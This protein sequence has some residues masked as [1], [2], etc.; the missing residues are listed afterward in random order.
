MGADACNL[1]VHVMITHSHIRSRTTD[2]MGCSPML[3]LPKIRNINRVFLSPKRLL[4]KM[5]LRFR[6][7]LVE[8]KIWFLVKH[9]LAVGIQLGD[10]ALDGIHG[11]TVDL[12]YLILVLIV[13]R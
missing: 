9:L 3:S 4:V 2:S 13:Y 11:L 7:K 10:L 12:I 1:V 6:N 8:M 5:K